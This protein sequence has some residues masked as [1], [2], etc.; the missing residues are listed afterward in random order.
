MLSG[1]SHMQHG[2]LHHAARRG[3][4]AAAEASNAGLRFA[5][6]GLSLRVCSQGSKVFC[7]QFA[8]MA[9][10]DVPQG[11]SMARYLERNDVKA[12]YQVACLG[13]TEADW[14]SLA[15]AAL[16]VCEPVAWLTT[17][18]RLLQVQKCSRAGSTCS[19]SPVRQQ[20]RWHIPSGMRVFEAGSCP[21][22]AVCWAA[23]SHSW[24]TTSQTLL[25]G[26]LPCR[27]WMWMLRVRPMFACVMFAL[28]SLSTVWQL[29]WQLE[30]HRTSCLLTWRHGKAILTRRPSC[31]CQRANWTRSA[32]CRLCEPV[33]LNAPI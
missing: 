16:Q 33:S 24:L 8:N 2:L 6:P 21:H 14:R 26:S 32:Q 18:S 11:S 17:G 29:V 15:Q 5:Y 27:P 7:L 19:S 23:S 10:I 30:H 12:A 9:T 22:Q 4:C 3:L 28:S 1:A 25:A 13:V 31:M 20:R